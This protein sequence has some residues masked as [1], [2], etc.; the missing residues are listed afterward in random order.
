MTQEALLQD[1]RYPEAVE[2]KE[3]YN[4]KYGYIPSSPWA[5]YAADALNV[6]AYVIDQTGSTDSD[7]LVDYLKNELENFPGI[8]GPIG[9]DEKG[10]RIGTGISLYVVT[11]T[12][13]FE[14]YTP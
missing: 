3:A 11:E 12:G 8:T 4:N 2:F 9:F 1:L 7:V 13:D 6:I 10:D 14:I 5:V